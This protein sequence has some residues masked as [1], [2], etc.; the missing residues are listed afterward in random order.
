MAPPDH[1]HG[2][3]FPP[4]PCP[5]GCFLALNICLDISYSLSLSHSLLSRCFLCRCLRVLYMHLYVWLS[6]FAFITTGSFLVLLRR[7]ASWALSGAA[8]EF[9]WPVGRIINETALLRNGSVR[10]A[11][12]LRGGAKR[13]PGSRP[14]RCGSGSAERVGREVP[15]EF[16]VVSTLQGDVHTPCAPAACKMRFPTPSQQVVTEWLPL[17]SRRGPRPMQP[18]VDHDLPL[19]RIRLQAHRHRRIPPEVP[20]VVVRMRDRWGSCVV[21]GDRRVLKALVLRSSGP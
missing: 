7:M 16:G 15:G 17:S 5:H 6:V 3:Q 1:R 11:R 4:K 13:F 8:V 12:W 19:R 20:S 10:R 2:W 18:P 14:L 9:S 21:E